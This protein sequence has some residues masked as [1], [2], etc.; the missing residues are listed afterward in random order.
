M[1]QGEGMPTSTVRSRR[2]LASTGTVVVVLTAS[3]LAAAPLAS[4]DPP[5]FWPV[6][7]QGLDNPR[8]LSFTG[9]TLY[10]AEAGVGGGGPCIDGPEG[11]ACFGL[12]GAI[13]RISGDH[14]SRVLTELPSLAGEGGGGAT[15]PADVSVTGTQRYAVTIGLGNEPEVRHDLPPA[16]N[17]LGTLVTG[18]FANS[19]PRLTADLAS[20]EESEDPD[21]AGADSNPTGLIAQRGGYVMTGSGG[22]TLVS[23]RGGHVSTLAVF[24]ARILPPGT[25]QP[26]GG[27]QAVPTSVAVGPDGAYYVSQL[28]GF[29]FP[30]GG[31]A[32]YRVV[33]GQ[34]PTV[35]AS[36]LT[37]VTDLAWSGDELYAVQ[38]ADGG[39]LGAPTGSLLRVGAGPGDQDVVAGGLFAPYGVALRGGSAYVTTCSVCAGGGTVIRVPLG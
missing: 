12:S 29:P 22:N 28:T 16:G 18:T 30:V 19:G 4:A 31:A 20:Y 17:Q 39:L 38:I 23:A 6:V 34:V 9:D 2:L 35:Y 37:N 33:P 32:I 1:T 5:P 13:T 24:P 27:M 8:Q 21:G 7:A 11:P 3:T 26:P 14:Q 36:G 15:G 10:V 25:P